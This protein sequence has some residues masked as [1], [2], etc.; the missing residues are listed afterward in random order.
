MYNIVYYIPFISITY[1]M[2][3]SKIITINPN[4]RKK[5]LQS[6]SRLK[7]FSKC[8][9]SYATY[10]EYPNKN[11]N[12]PSWKAWRL[13]RRMIIPWD[14]TSISFDIGCSLRQKVCLWALS[15]PIIYHFIFVDALR[16]HLVLPLQ[17]QQKWYNCTQNDK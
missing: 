9:T 1:N 16:T 15:S 4:F 17:I 11:W 10:L 14:V 7:L 12:Y 3:Y 6:D 2:S 5:V 8:G 13:Y